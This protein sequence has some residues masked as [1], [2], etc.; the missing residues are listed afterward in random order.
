M[1]TW[2]LAKIRYE[3]A[4]E[5]GMNKKVTESYLIDALSFTEAEARITNE[6]KAFISGDFSVTALKL[7]N[8]QEIFCSAAEKDEKWYKVKIAFVSLDEKS[9]KDR[10]SYSY[11]L[12]QSSDTANAEKRLHEGMKGTMCKYEV[13]EVIESKIMDVYPYILEGETDETR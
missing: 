5:N 13:L 2:F 6:M 8:I 10:K 4:M 12:V 1:G 9:G 7:E 3:K 11:M